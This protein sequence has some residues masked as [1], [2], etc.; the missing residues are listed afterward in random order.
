M[1]QQQVFT[2]AIWGFDKKAVL[3]YIYEQDM[4]LKK[5]EAEYESR[6]AEYEEKLAGYEQTAP[7]AEQYQEQLDALTVSYNEE[8][9]TVVSLQSRYDKLSDEIDKLL[10]VSSNKER[11]LQLQLEL[12]SQLKYKCEMLEDKLKV[13]AEHLIA[14]RELESSLPDPSIIPHINKPEAEEP[15]VFVAEAIEAAA[16]VEYVDLK[17]ELE[18]FRQSVSKTLLNFEAALAKLESGK[19][20]DVTVE[21]PTFFR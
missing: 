12:N 8:K 14:E 6:I 4:L 13:L 2:T 21:T 20:E 15:P 17:E 11:E 19:S 10:K 3:D 16:P 9:E 5:K 7:V 1:E 18:E